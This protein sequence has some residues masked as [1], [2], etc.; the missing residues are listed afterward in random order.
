[1]NPTIIRMV[2]TALFGLAALGIGGAMELMEI[3]A[4][5]WLVGIIG[6]AAGYLFGHVQANGFDGRKRHD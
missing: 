3:G 1:M 6:L 5:E 2:T 4:P